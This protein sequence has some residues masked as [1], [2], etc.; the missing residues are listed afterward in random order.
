[1]MRE[2]I[3]RSRLMGLLYVG[4]CKMG[5]GE[6]ACVQVGLKE[7]KLLKDSRQREEKSQLVAVEV[8]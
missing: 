5:G 4:D 6:S 3:W 1:M 8:G 2:E 7:E